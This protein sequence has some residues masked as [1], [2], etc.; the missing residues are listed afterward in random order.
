M[1]DIRPWHEIEDVIKK[2]GVQFPH[3]LNPMVQRFKRDR[4]SATRRAVD[5]MLP[6]AT[7]DLPM[8]EYHSARESAVRL[9]DAYG[10]GRRWVVRKGDEAIH[11]RRE[12]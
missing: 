9:A 5:A 4:W 7:L 6:G 12:S 8:A 10:D 2:L 3:V 1:N 11:V